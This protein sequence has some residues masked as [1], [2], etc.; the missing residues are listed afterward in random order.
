MSGQGS[1]TKAMECTIRCWE[2]VN[3]TVRIAFGPINPVDVVRSFINCNPSEFPVTLIF[4]IFYVVWCVIVLDTNI[5]E[6]T[7][8]V[9][10]TFNVVGATLAFILPLIAASAVARNKEALNNYNAFCGDVLALGWE[11][12]AYIRDETKNETVEKDIGRI[13]ELFEICLALPT[14]VKWKFR[15][16]LDIEKVYMVKFSEKDKVQPETNKTKRRRYSA[17]TN[18]NMIRYPDL[19]VKKFRRQFIRT[20]VGERF[21]ELYL[22]VSNTE[23]KEGKKDTKVTKPKSGRTKKVTPSTDKSKNSDREVK[24]SDLDDQS[25]PVKEETKKTRRRGWWS[26][27][28]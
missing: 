27:N 15:G 24:P 14:M 20:N 2:I 18:F 7:P 22:K 3:K 1:C 26:K 4:M 12:L 10:Q 23:E 25:E 13:Q 6:T 11:V 21:K 19:G 9:S 16:G 28:S 8:D 5:H 17:L